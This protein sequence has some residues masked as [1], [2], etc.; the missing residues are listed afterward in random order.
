VARSVRNTLPPAKV[1]SAMVKIFNCRLY[2]FYSLL[3]S[4]VHGHLSLRDGCDCKRNPCPYTNTSRPVFLC[5]PRSA[6]ECLFD[7]PVARQM[8]ESIV[9]T[10]S[11]IRNP[12]YTEHN[13]T[14]C[15]TP[16][17]P[18]PPSNPNQLFV[19]QTYRG[20]QDWNV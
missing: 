5:V 16:S 20:L 4:R 7:L 12:V 8:F 6:E 17:L 19:T 15:I 9:F 13:I 3:L 18:T 2:A 14:V 1:Y 10:A 11:L